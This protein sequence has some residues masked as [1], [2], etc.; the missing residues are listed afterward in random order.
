MNMLILIRQ[1]LTCG[2]VVWWYGNDAW[3]AIDR[4]AADSI[5]GC[6]LSAGD[7]GKAVLAQARDEPQSRNAAGTYNREPSDD[8]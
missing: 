3:L 4:E 8:K 6:T 7:S 2:V 5:S 1:K